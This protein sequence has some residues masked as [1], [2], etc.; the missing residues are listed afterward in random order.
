MINT[1]FT[2]KNSTQRRIP[3]TPHRNAMPCVSITSVATT[4]HSKTKHI[5]DY[6]QSID[7]VKNFK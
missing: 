3:N 1:K 6:K 5:L 2:K 7:S 4:N